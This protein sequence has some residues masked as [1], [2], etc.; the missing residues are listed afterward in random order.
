MR[1][2][3]FGFSSYC[4]HRDASEFPED[5]K[6][7]EVQGRLTAAKPAAPQVAP[8]AA[9]SPQ[10]VAPSHD[11]DDL[12]IMEAAPPQPTSTKRKRQEEAE[13]EKEKKHKEE[14]R[15]SKRQRKQQEQ[16]EA[17]NQKASDSDAIVLD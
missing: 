13:E 1:G 16:E 11:E 3:F 17:S 9:I 8:A 10:A 7:F 15:L 14:E 6:K 12:V 5:G 4:H 2:C